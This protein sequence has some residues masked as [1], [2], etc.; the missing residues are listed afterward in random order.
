MAY[1]MYLDGILMPVTPSKVKIKIK[2]QNETLNLINGEEINILKSAGLSDISF[3]LLLPQVSYPFAN[4]NTNSAE[5]YLNKIEELKISKKSF[6]WILSR[7]RTNGKNLFHSNMTVSLEDYQITE[8]A[9]QGF[10][11]SVSV[12]LK[13]YKSYGTKTV[14][15]KP[16]NTASVKK[17]NRETSQA[18][19]QP[20]YTVKTGDCLWNIAK[21]YLGNGMRYQEIYELNK[22]KIKPSYIIYTGQVLRMPTK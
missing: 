1:K 13:Q 10:D 6:Q 16:S 18:P 7:E 20:T 22:D 15:V 12:N 2:N 8:D 9:E 5:Y 21:K 3:D 17:P 19:K 4:K 11:I 14:V